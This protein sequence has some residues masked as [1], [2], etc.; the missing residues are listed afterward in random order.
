M[1]K[2]KVAVTVDGS[3]LQAVDKEVAKGTYLSRSQAVEEALSLLLK[4]RRGNESLLAALALLDPEEEVA[5][6]EEWLEGEPW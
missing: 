1:A 6:A 4:R 2:I 3:V 5:L